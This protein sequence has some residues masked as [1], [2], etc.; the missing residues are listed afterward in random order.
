MPNSPGCFY[1]PAEPPTHLCRSPSL[2]DEGMHRCNFSCRSAV[3]RDGSL[4]LSLSRNF[5]LPFLNRF[6]VSTDHVLDSLW[7][8]VSLWCSPGGRNSFSRCVFTDEDGHGRRGA[9]HG[10]VSNHDGC[11]TKAQT[12]SWRQCRIDARLRQTCV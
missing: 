12:A 11:P 4:F 3:D 1:T 10:A 7:L 5:W 9:V 8:P 2:W 6:F